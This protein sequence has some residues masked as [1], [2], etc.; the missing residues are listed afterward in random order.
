M[1]IAI[2]LLNI[3]DCVHTEF[4]ITFIFHICYVENR[5]LNQKKLEEE[6][7]NDNNSSDTDTD[8]ICSSCSTCSSTSQFDED[9]DDEN[10][11]DIGEEEGMFLR[12]ENCGK[13]FQY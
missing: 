3:H 5:V 9:D 12:N 11:Y 13:Q 2:V 6:N 8:S 10:G 4:I 7:D 1:Y